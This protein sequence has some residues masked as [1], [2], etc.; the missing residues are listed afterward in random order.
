M[1]T[2]RSEQPGR[3][4]A[5]ISA[6]SSSLAPGGVVGDGRYR[7]LAQFGVDERGAAHFWRARDGQLRRDVALTILA[8]DPAD[9]AA[10][11][12]ARRTLERAAHAGQ[13]S[14]SGMA[15]IL[16]VLS[17]GDGISSGEGI[18]GIVVADWVRSSDLLDLL[19]H[20]EQRPLPPAVA[21]RMTYALAEAVDQAHQSGLVLGIDHPQRLRATPDG[22]LRVAFAGPLPEATLRDD[23]KALGAVLYLL[24]TGR[25]PLD[26]GPEGIPAAPRSP[27][28]SVLPPQQLDSSV[29]SALSSL[30][31]RTIE[32]GEAGGI[33]T[34]SA[35]LRV[36]GEAAEQEEQAQRRKAA[37][38]AEDDVEPDGSVWTTKKPVKDQA[39]RRKLA[40]GVTVVVVAAVAV[41]GWGGMSLI[42][43][44]QGDTGPSGPK[45]NVGATTQQQPESAK[46]PPTK[47]ENAGNA[48][49][50]APVPVE[51]STIRLYNPGSSGDNPADAGKA[52]D[53]DPATIWQTD[54]Y[55]QQL[56]ALKPGLG[57]LATFDK[58]VRL[59]EVKITADSPGTFVEI[60]TAPGPNPPLGATHTVAAGPLTGVQT[61]ITLDKPAQT[62]HVLVWVTKLGSS[63]GQFQSEIGEIDF[64]AKPKAR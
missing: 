62:R 6:R 3:P 48:K 52:I 45:L 26:G 15:R 39:R 13:F 8:G 2:N 4:R 11:A 40:M 14:H 21:A 28:N 29:P 25:W 9:A 27:S 23:V 17:L 16:D 38:D 1:D 33:R 12:R 20:A 19:G 32:D 22:K 43:F 31:V 44:F 42:N 7:L 50:Q 57:L 37:G 59:S 54:L 5:S 58:P 41:L 63:Q 53:G 49:Q 36:L 10:A 24:L 56:P 35:I 61:T 18:L 60:R 55:K 46:P 30:A 51:A 47:P 34:S 64:V